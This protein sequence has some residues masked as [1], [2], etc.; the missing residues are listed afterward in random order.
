ML[1]G[2]KF[3]ADGIQG[4]LSHGHALPK[5]ERSWYE[6]PASVAVAAHIITPAPI[7]L[8]RGKTRLNMEGA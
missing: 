7:F 8:D 3:K 2:P 1:A 6:T 5:G 4:F